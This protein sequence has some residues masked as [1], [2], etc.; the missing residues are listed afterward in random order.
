MSMERFGDYLRFLRLERG[1]SLRSFCR[2][3]EEDPGNL[4]RIERGIMRPPE[5]TDKLKNWARI[6]GIS[7]SDKE[8]CFLDLADIARGNVPDD[9]LDEEIAQKLP[10]V[11]RTIRGE[12]INK[13]TLKKIAEMIREG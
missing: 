6:L 9:L 5:N 1:L 11:F 7:G 12:R 13:N 8:E 2:E 4:S 10:L 3:S